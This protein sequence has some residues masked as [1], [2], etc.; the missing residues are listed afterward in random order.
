MMTVSD[1]I[2]GILEEEIL[3]V[4]DSYIW[5]FTEIKKHVVISLSLKT[6]GTLWETISVNLYWAARSI[7]L[8]RAYIKTSNC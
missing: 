5:R 2:I 4:V 7:S 1:I 8:Y 6:Y 3:A